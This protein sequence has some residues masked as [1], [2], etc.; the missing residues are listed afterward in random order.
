MYMTD[1]WGYMRVARVRGRPGPGGS[2]AA[3]LPRQPA[4]SLSTMDH[5]SR[6]IEKPTRTA[7]LTQGRIGKFRRGVGEKI[8]AH[9]MPCQSEPGR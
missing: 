8:P 7:S 3:V 9:R 4:T 6:I 5:F 1:C 2:A